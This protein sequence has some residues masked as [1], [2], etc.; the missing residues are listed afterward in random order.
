MSERLIDNA[1]VRRAQRGEKR[2]FDLLVS[3]YQGRVIN[4]V[5]RYVS[6]TTERQDIA[7]EAFIKAYR[8]IA[9][10]RGDSAFYTWLYRIAVNTAKNALVAQ[11]RRPPGTD[12]EAGE[13]EHFDLETA[14]VHKDT[15]EHQLLKLEIKNTVED[16]IARLPDDLRAALTLREARGMSY[17]QIAEAMGCPIGTI[18]SRIF[19]A[20][21]AVFSRLEPLLS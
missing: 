2:A 10:F 18:R 5:G 13:V 7:Q 4:L 14:L 6:D 8:S 15:P 16:A 12:I 11:R 19:R 21:E 17:A 3:K 9:R 1:L 20:R